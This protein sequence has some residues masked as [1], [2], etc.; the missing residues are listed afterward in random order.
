[1]CGVAPLTLT[2]L[3]HA[4]PPD[5]AQTLSARHG[6]PRHDG[7]EDTI[8]SG[9]LECGGCGR[10]FA[11]RSGVADLVRDA[12]RRD[13]DERAF[14]KE[15]GSRVPSRIVREGFPVSSAPRALA[16]T[17][18]DRRILGEDSYWG[19]FMEVYWN[20][21]DRSIF[22]VRIKGLHPAL[23]G[24]GVTAL[25]ER[26]RRRRVGV[27][28]DRT[29]DVLFGWMHEVRGAR[30][31]DAGCG[32]GQFGLEAARRGMRVIGIDPSRR[33][34]EL[35]RSHAR[36]TNA[37][38]DYVRAE[39]DHPPFLAG[40]FGVLLAKD[41]LHHIPNLEYALDQLEALL[42]PDARVCIW[43]H[44]GRSPRKR[45]ILGALFRRLVPAIQ[46]KYGTVEVPPILLRESDNEDTGM[47]RIAGELQRRFT[48]TRVRRE[49]FLDHDVEM[50]AYYRLGRRALPATLARLAARAV[51][52]V[53]LTAGE[54]AEFVAYTGVRAGVGP[55]AKRQSAAADSGDAASRSGG[56]AAIAAGP[57][58]SFATAPSVSRVLNRLAARVLPGRDARRPW[59]SSWSRKEKGAWGERAAERH[60][61]A[62]G[63]RILNRNLHIGDGEID[64]LTEDHGQMVFVEVK[65]RDSDSAIAPHLAVDGE[66]LRVLRRTA[67]LW[68]ARKPT[69]WPSIRLD[70]VGVTPDPRTGL[71]VIDHHPGAGWLRRLESAE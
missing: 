44:V 66:K 54:P 43:E 28:P 42:H 35:A 47:D 49:L 41:S 38:I 24:Q 9:T 7:E 4:E 69:P 25:D 53:L 64:L 33:E 10:W 3:A 26:D 5:H 23:L 2:V 1:M 45:R 22:D 55:G 36:E 34:L 68:L 31:L 20:L 46:R 57:Q 51:E 37:P 17:E 39:P 59:N 65:T 16:R 14:L 56:D 70:I 19:E 30:A 71:P 32:G 67:R 6:L 48:P 11:I 58:A 12:L 8:E 15:H 29:S 40:S 50:L 18:E 21:G 61:S 13:D 62:D 52:L 27:W 60:L 63:H